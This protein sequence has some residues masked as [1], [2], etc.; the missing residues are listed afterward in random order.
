MSGIRD[1]LPSL[2]VHNRH[3]PLYWTHLFDYGHT[4]TIIW[5]RTCFS[6][7]RRGGKSETTEIYLRLQSIAHGGLGDDRSPELIWRE[8]STD[9]SASEA[10]D[11]QS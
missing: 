2:T 5:G 9:S 10:L 7:N 6:R 1:A 3:V 11:D 4:T 8:T